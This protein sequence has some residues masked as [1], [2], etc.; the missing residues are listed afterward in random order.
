MTRVLRR[1]LILAIVLM[2]ICILLFMES[3]TYPGE[4]SFYPW[5]ILSLLF[6]LSLVLFIR[7]LSDRKKAADLQLPA[8]L[9]PKSVLLMAGLTAIYIFVLIPFIGYYPSTFLFILVSLFYFKTSRKMGL[10]TMGVY[11]L[12]V[13]SFFELWLGVRMP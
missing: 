2:G 11:F 4:S 13:Y 6:L 1:D 7:T 3:R 10:I 8:S 5:V 9:L 12:I